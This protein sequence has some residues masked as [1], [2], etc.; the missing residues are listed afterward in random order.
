AASLPV[1]D[2]FEPFDGVLYRLVLWSILASLLAAAVLGWVTVRLL[3][4]LVR[5]RDTLQ[6]LRTT[7]SRFTPVPVQQRDEIGE[8]TEAFN[9]LMSERDRLQQELEARA[10][11]LEQERDRAEA[12]NRAKSDFVANMS[13]EI[14]TPLNAVLGMVYLLGNTKLDTEQRKYLTMVRVAGQSLLGILNDVLD[15]SK[16]EARRMELSPVEFDLDEVMNTLATTMTMNAGEKE[17]EL[18]IAVEP[19]VPRRLVGDAQRL[20]QIL[21]NLAG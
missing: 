6:A 4:P 11:E 14:R 13:H 19:D 10:A 3:S 20:Q 17:L 9:G 7:G 5:L 12:A 8:L 15:Y 18:A 2:A 1:D 21:V 16:I